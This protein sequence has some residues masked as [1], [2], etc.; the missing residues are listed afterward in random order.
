MDGWREG[1]GKN[2][3]LAEG[4]VEI[5]IYTYVSNPIRVVL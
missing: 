3:P 4:R 1:D 5:N 2:F